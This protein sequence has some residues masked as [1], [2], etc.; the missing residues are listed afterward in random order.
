MET[1]LTRACDNG[2]LILVQ[3]LL[4]DGAD[5]NEPN[6]HGES[7]LMIA[8]AINNVQILALLAEFGSEINKPYHQ[9][10]TAL[11][12]AID[13]AIGSTI[14]RGGQVGDEPIEAIVWLLEHGADPFRKTA[15]GYTALDIAELYRA[16]TV[17]ALVRSYMDAY[18]G[19]PHAPADA[20]RRS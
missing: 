1:Q 14:T 6:G 10:F 9:G 19:Q 4:H 18:M 11:H 7:P 17:A 20:L 3:K 16:E 5:P 13:S 12:M 2:D 8:A 15:D